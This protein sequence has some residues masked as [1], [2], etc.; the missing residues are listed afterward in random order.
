MSLIQHCKAFLRRQGRLYEPVRAWR[1]RRKELEYSRLRDH[2]LHTGE[3]VFSPPGHRARAAALWRQ[4][5]TAAP[6]PKKSL[7]EVNIFV[8]DKPNIIGF[9]FLAEFARAA[10]VTVYNITR[11]QLRYARGN[12]EDPDWVQSFGEE[13]RFTSLPSLIAN[14]HRS[15]NYHNRRGQMG[16]VFGVV[17]MVAVEFHGRRISYGKSPCTIGLTHR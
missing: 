9:W 7:A 17:L 10:R 3:K 6:R 11:H 14:S 8:V 5:R 4:Q 2:Y 13:D 12:R 15:S 16:H 1:A